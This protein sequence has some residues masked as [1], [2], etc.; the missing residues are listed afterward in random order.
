MSANHSPKDLSDLGKLEAD[1][2]IICHACGRKGTFELWP[3]VN[4]FR[5]RGWSTLWGNVACRFRCRGTANDPGCGSKRL[6]AHM[7]PRLK[8]PPPQPRM[9]ELQAMQKAKRER[10]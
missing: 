5:S 4:H 1:L 10:R 8:L 7:A 3:I 2:L 6:S 9:T